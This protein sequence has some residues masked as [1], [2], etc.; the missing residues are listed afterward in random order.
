MKLRPHTPLARVGIARNVV[1]SRP[2]EFNG[3]IYWQV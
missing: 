1:A 3:K 2:G